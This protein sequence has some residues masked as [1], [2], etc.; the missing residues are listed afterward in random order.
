MQPINFSMNYYALK[1]FGRQQ[2]SNAWAAISELVANGF[3]AGAKNVYLYINMINKANAMIEIIDDGS[4]M[5]ELDLSEKYTK[6]GRNRREENPDDKATGRKGIGK[7]AALYL[8]DS[9][10]I[11][12]KKDGKITS[13]EVDVSGKLDDD[14]PCLEPIDFN[15]EKII[16]SDVWSAFDFKSGT[17]IR[18][19]NVNLERIG[20][21]ALESL[22]QKLSN[23]FTFDTMDCQLNVCII[24]NPQDSLVFEK[25]NK[26]IAFDNM[27]HIYTSDKTLIV[28]QKNNFSVDFTDKMGNK[29]TIEIPKVIDN[30][31]ETVVGITPGNKIPTAGFAEFY[32]VTKQYAIKGWIGIHST[33]DTESARKD[34]TRFIRNQFY[35]PNQLRI[36]VRNKLANENIL[37]KLNLT[38]TYENYIEG[39]LAFDILDDND[40][41]DIAT[42]NRQG[43][44]VVDER[45]ELLFQLTRALCLQLMARRQELADT[46]KIAK[47]KL[48]DVIT[49][50][51]KS[52]FVQETHT[53]LRTAG[54]PEE[55]ADELSR[56]ISNKLKGEYELKDS[57]KIFISHASKD[58]IFSD[59]ITNFLQFKGFKWS[60]D[61]KDSDIFYSADGTDI[62]DGTPL[63]EIIKKMILDANTDILFLTSDSFMKSQ[64]CLFEGGAAW[65]TRA[66]LEYGII[67]LD[68][69]SIPEFLT[70]GK[71]EFAFNIKDRSSFN[72]NKQNYSN[73][74]YILNRLIS[75]LNNNRK[76]SGEEEVALIDSP[77]FA[78]LVQMKKE[79]KTDTDYMD[80]DVCEYWNTYVIEQL[81]DYYKQFEL[82]EKNNK[83]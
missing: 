34:D 41:E 65:A 11:I 56:V 14:I 53:D 5:N 75:H 64:Y 16:C 15:S 62:E 29:K 50:K 2:Y 47:N 77:N 24:A 48:D 68:Y 74:V 13:W 72:L 10:Q 30:I 31:P 51:Q 4:G 82:Q 70:N 39:E 20:N 7:L 9:Y 80:K 63:S 78:N 18:L 37:D 6:I 28:S 33:I 54:I 12:S 46:L 59:F 52:R 81:D 69:N 17:A 32:G 3:D 23:Y 61:Y 76:I 26:Q 8:S 27:V 58:R 42:A 38:G 55:R 66:I 83:K 45:V 67:A 60:K 19:L 44:S 40:Y 22:K 35:S 49:S 1:T 21:R 25:I 36:Y 71:P 43:F 57:Y 73:L 79:G